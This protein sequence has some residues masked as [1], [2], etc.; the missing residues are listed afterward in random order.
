MLDNFEKDTKDGMV[1]G[2]NEEIPVENNPN[3]EEAMNQM[4]MEQ[5]NKGY[6][7]S[8]NP[9][10]ENSINPNSMNG[11][12]NYNNS[13][14]NDGNNNEK[15]KNFNGQNPYYYSMNHNQSNN[16]NQNQGYPPNNYYGNHQPP[17]KNKSGK[18]GMVVASILAGVLIIG[19]SLWATGGNG[20]DSLFSK[21][22]TQ[23]ESVQDTNKGEQTTLSKVE[24][25]KEN[26]NQSTNNSIG[27]TNQAQ[28][29]LLDV[30]DVVEEVMPSVVAISLN[31]EYTTNNGFF[32]QQIQQ[33]TA[34]GSGVIIG[35]ND[36]ELLIVTNAHVVSAEGNQYYTISNQKIAV[37]FYGDSTFDAYIKGTDDEADLAV[38][39]VKISDLNDEVKNNIKIATIGDSDACKVGN[40]VIA[41]GNAL[42]YGQSTTVGYISALN[43]Q[44]TVDD[45]ITRTLLQTDAAINPG[46]SGGGLFNTNGE[47]IGINAAKYADED[48]EGIGYAIPITSAESIINELMNKVAKTPVAEEKRGM[49]GI[50]GGDVP[51]A[52]VTNYNYPQGA[53]ISKIV[54]GTPAYD[55]ELQIYDIITEVNGEK[56][57]SFADLQEEITYYEAGTTVELTVQR[58]DGRTFKEYKVN[59]TL[60]N[61][62]SVEQ[63]TQPET[64]EHSLFN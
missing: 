17:K 4:N 13:M 25:N 15:Q 41:I 53:F 61:K 35:E 55:S 16:G 57:R 39:A 32:G 46:N 56:V 42:G 64:K 20:K 36:E 3:K 14:N 40:G 63:S 34:S 49:L 30:S 28:A 9:M 45:N 22:N 29:V 7:N 54:E 59:V 44:V 2:N 52:Y 51:S 12:S 19:T 48:V 58:T 62:D 60:A 24:D 5:S 6:S 21:Q 11:N 43:R 27:T 50:Q 23:N 8:P 31:L 33:G 38:I 1:S 37:T 18:V 10:N 47:L 26:S